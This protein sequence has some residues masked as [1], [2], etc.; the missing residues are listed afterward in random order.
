M[1]KVEQPSYEPIPARLRQ[2]AAHYRGLAQAAKLPGEADRY[3]KI[4]QLLDDEANS[5]ERYPTPQTR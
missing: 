3:L 1:E 4:S 5:I 2:R